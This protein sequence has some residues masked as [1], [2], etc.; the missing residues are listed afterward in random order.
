[1]QLFVNKI[2]SATFPHNFAFVQDYFFF[3]NGPKTLRLRQ[4]CSKEEW[5]ENAAEE[6]AQKLGVRGYSRAVV[7]AGISRARGIT[8]A[9]ALRRVDKDEAKIG[10][11][12]RQHR[13]IV[14]YDRRSCPVLATILKNNY[15]AA[16]ARDTRFSLIFRKVPKPV[17]RKGT[18]VKQLLCR[19]KPPQAHTNKTQASIREN[20]GSV[21][22]CNKGLN[23]NNCRAC[24][25]LTMAPQDVMK[26]VKIHSSSGIVKVEGKLNC[27]SKS[28]LYVLE[29]SKTSKGPGS[30]PSQYVGQS[31]ST[32]ATRLGGT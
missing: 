23:R 1:M 6:L 27:K 3:I 22:R 26:E 13:L 24:P 20:Q 2:W 32:V 14:E 7:Q 31:G 8:R 17:Y 30:P 25:V 29:P 4:I 19:A 21:T 16:A 28:F 18:N 10:G 15:E 9:E 11:K 5:F 12:D